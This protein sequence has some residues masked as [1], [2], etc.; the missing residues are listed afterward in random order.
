LLAEYG[1]ILP[2]HLS[3]V[4]KQLPEL[5]SEDHPLLTSYSRDLFASLYEE[6]CALDE[7]IQAMEQ[8]IQRVFANNEQCQKIAANEGVRP[9]TAT[10]MLRP[11]L[12]AKPFVMD[13]S[14]PPGWV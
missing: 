9:V 4:R 2:L 3:E 6:L 12:T 14:S 10:A 7:R 8:R 5:F 1:I 13:G 11:S